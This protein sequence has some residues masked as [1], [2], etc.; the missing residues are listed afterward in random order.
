AWSP[1]ARAAG[2]STVVV[3][4]TWTLNGPVQAPC[5]EVDAS[6]ACP[7]PIVLTPPPFIGKMGPP[8]STDGDLRTATFSQATCAPAPCTA[9]LSTSYRGY[10]GLATGRGSGGL[11]DAAGD[12]HTFQFTFTL[13]GTEL[14]IRGNAT[15]HSTGEL[16]DVF[17]TF[18]VV[19]PPLE[20]AAGTATAF[21]TAGDLT[22][23]YPKVTP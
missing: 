20:C 4:G 5:V 15:R 12:A 8:F 23:T 16:G 14:V 13:V 7:P 17:G 6:H 21:P 11:L 1:P 18:A 10:C 3:T 9:V 22:V 2:A 19:S